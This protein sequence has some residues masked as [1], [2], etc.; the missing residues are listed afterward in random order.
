[1]DRMA[2]VGKWDD[3]WLTHPVPT[4]AERDKRVCL[5]TDIDSPI[6]DS[7]EQ[8]DQ[9]RHAARLYLKG[10]FYAVDQFFMQVR[11]RLSLTERPRTVNSGSFVHQAALNIESVRARTL[12]LH[13]K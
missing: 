6:D 9:Q 11:R 1:M 12:H 10:H 3:R 2:S 5:L 4:K 13:S 8:K 7:S